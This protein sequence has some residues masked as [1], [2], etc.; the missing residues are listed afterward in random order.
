M[1][2]IWL[3]AAIWVALALIA[4]LIAKRTGVSVAL[5]EI[6]VGVV[7]GNLITI[8]SKAE[9]VGFLAGFGGIS[10]LFGYTRGIINQ[11]QYTVLVTVVIGSALIPTMIA[12]AFFRPRIEE[13]SFRAPGSKPESKPEAGPELSGASMLRAP[14]AQE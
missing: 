9:W 2:S 5:V 13:A 10:A 7:A 4:G 12:Q 8:N 6:L 14:E 1:E 11:Y 3:N